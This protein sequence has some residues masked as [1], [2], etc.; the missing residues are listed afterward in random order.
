MQNLI[1]IREIS[2]TQLRNYLSLSFQIKK[3]P[4]Q[5]SQK[6]KGKNILLFFV[7][8]STR[9]KLSFENAVKKLGGN[10]VSFAGGSSSM[11]KGE[12]LLDTV[13]TIQQYGLDALV[14]RHSSSGTIDWL[15]KASQLPAINAGDGQHEHPTQ[16]LLDVFTLM[17]HWNISAD[18]PNPLQG[19]KV[20]IVG[21]IFHSRVA[22]SNIHALTKLGA[23]VTLVAPK[24]LLP[25]DLSLFPK[26]NVLHRWD[27][28]EGKERLAEA[29]A[30]MMLRLQL[31]RQK[32]AF[33]PT[34]AEYRHFWGLTRERELLLKPS[35]VILHPGP[36]NHGVEMDTEVVSSKK[37]LILKQVENGVWARMA[38]F[39]GVLK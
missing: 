30:V 27:T 3:N 14:M 29:D 31:E 11:S 12:S 5:F 15:S 39:V 9:T 23:E 18:Q 21:D 38:A 36:V 28:E 33:F 1:T 10:I 19:K 6:L 8:N 22:R 17:E 34:A 2:E 26:V 35:A 32:S 13:Q 16:A 24:T 4:E 7:E 20:M 37:S 25:S